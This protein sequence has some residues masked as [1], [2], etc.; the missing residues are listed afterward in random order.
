MGKFLGVS[1]MASYLSKRNYF[2]VNSCCH[3]LNDLFALFIIFSKSWKL[4]YHILQNISIDIDK[5]DEKKKKKKNLGE[6]EIV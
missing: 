1:E 2:C 4:E 5:T 6:V 3:N